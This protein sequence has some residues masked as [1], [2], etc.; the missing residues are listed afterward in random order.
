[1]LL[2]AKKSLAADSQA[3]VEAK[4]VGADQPCDVEKHIH[5]KFHPQGFREVLDWDAFDSAHVFRSDPNT[6][7]FKDD[8]HGGGPREG[9]GWMF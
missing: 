5:K 9:K 2:A 6:C 8:G 3:D 1:M 4:H 7:S